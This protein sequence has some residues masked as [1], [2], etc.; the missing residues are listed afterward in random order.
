MGKIF[1]YKLRQNSVCEISQHLLA[2][3]S[4]IIVRKF[5]EINFNFVLLS[6]FAK[7]KNRLSYTPYWYF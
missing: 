6:Y 5:R 7:Y 1:T 3:F 2:K 4:N